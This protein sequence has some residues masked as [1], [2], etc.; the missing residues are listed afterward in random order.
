MWTPEN[1]LKSVFPVQTQ[2]PRS[3]DPQ[4]P[5]RPRRTDL[6]VLPFPEYSHISRQPFWPPQMMSSTTF[7]TANSTPS[8]PSCSSACRTVN[9]SSPAPSD[10]SYHYS[11]TSINSYKSQKNVLYPRRVHWQSVPLPPIAMRP[12]CTGV[13]SSDPDVRFYI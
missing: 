4:V 7:Y 13:A 3:Q 2:V 8:S 1:G 10:N 12:E 9:T 5:A 11:V 6:E